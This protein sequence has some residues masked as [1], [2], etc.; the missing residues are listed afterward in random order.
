MNKKI[1][2]ILLITPKIFCGDVQL[3]S[4]SEQSVYEQKLNNLKRIVSILKERQLQSPLHQS[5]ERLDGLLQQHQLNAKDLGTEAVTFFSLLQSPIQQPKGHSLKKAATGTAV[6]GTLAAIMALINDQQKITRSVNDNGSNSLAIVALITSIIAL[7]L[8]AA[9]FI[10]S[11]FFNRNEIIA[12]N[13]NKRINNISRLVEAQGNQ[14]G[15]VSLEQANQ[16]LRLGKV[17]ESVSDTF[18]SL[19]GYE[20]VSSREAQPSGQ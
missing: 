15:A 18:A 10:H 8:Q 9:T 13:L 5:L 14:I 11:K 16:S 1:I 4:S 12:D 19:S 17:I 2:F 3:A 7:V 20:V 6:V